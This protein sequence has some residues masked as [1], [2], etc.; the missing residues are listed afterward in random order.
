M[1]TKHLIFSI[2]ALVSSCAAI[3]QNQI[4]VDKTPPPDNTTMV[5]LVTFDDASIKGLE[6]KLSE[7]D[8]LGYPTIYLRLNSNGGSISAAMSLIQF[9][10]Q[11]KTPLTC[12]ADWHAFSAAFYTLE[13]DACPV[14]LMTKRAVLLAHAALVMDISGNAK[15]LRHEAEALDAISEALISVTADRMKMSE[16]DFKAQ[17]DGRNWWMSYEDAVKY[18]AIDKIVD[19]SSLPKLESYQIPSSLEMLLNSLK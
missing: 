17:I 14:R 1:N 11:M 9:A 19:P 16:K 7:L 6:D 8:K 10:E 15:E 13:S 2:L 12:V 3:S 5:E 18:H 4:K